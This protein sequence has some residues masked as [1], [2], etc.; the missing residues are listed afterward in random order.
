MAHSPE[1]GASAPPEK[2]E[3]LTALVHE[4]RHRLRNAYAVSGA[5]AVAS[6][7]ETPEHQDFAA[8]LAQRFITLSLV[9]TR[10]LDD[11]GSERLPRLAEQLTGAF[12]SGPGA[13]SLDDLPD[14][15]LDEQQARLIGLVLGELCANSVRH[16]AFAGG[17]G[18]VALSG[19]V[20]DRRL[21]IEWREPLP[22]APSSAAGADEAAGRRL[23]SRMARAHGGSLAW[24]QGDRL[25]VAR[26]ELS[27]AG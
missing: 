18:P 1:P 8:A 3:R 16:G 27:L 22:S 21:T 13:V 24:Q 20:A 23:L 15:P 14:V 10:L 26:L 7:R 6:G 5:I 4:L 19:A 11:P 12:A 2:V 9:Q 25:L 17:Q